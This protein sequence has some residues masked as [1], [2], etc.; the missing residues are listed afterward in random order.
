[1]IGENVMTKRG[2]GNSKNEHQMKKQKKKW[3]DEKLTATP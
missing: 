3:T 2:Q 1:M